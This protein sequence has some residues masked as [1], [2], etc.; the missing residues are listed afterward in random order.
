MAN[1]DKI[2]SELLRQGKTEKVRSFDEILEKISNVDAKEKQ[3]W[4][5]IYENAI[6]D[7]NNAYCMFTKLVIIVDQNSTEFAIHGRNI[8]FYLERMSKSN[9][10]LIKLADLIAQ[11]HE[12]N[13]KIDPDDM[14]SRISRG[15]N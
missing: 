11:A 9:D 5:E 7:R 15:K 4:R 3:L 2:M 1:D 12:A 10:Q 14:Y 6:E 13:D 8:A